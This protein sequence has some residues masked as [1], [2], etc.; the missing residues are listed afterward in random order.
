M[1]LSALIVACEVVAIE[2]ALNIVE[3]DLFLV[4]AFPSIIGG[5]ILMSICPKESVRFAVALGRRGWMLFLLMGAFITAGV[6]LWFD[7]VSRIGASKE[8]IL[9]GGST[10]VLFVVILSGVF[11]HER[12]TAMES[13]GGV[14][15]ILGVIFVLVDPSAM[16]LTLGVGEVEAI[17]SSL[18][19]SVSVIITT[20]LLKE[21]ALT[22]LSGWELFLGGI[23]VLLCGLA[24]GSVEWPHAKGMLILVLLGTFPALGLL[25][26]NAGLP[27]I[28]A[29][30]TSVLFALTG[31]MTVGVQL[32][33]LLFCP[34]ADIT[35][36][37]H[38][39]LALL[40]GTIAVVGV[41]MLNKMPGL[42]P[43]TNR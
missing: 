32:L 4:S 2:A 33:I 41:Y 9:G 18:S 21:H 5:L 26:Y 37:Q 19:L 40:G 11:L 28:G 38:V 35:L 25:T 30:L 31:I 14:L 34:D 3:L 12:L 24:F 10:E 13:F 8:A 42:R 23:M 36:P 39:P 17:A 6:L 1:L 43:L 16:R 7:S 20:V 29:S 22:P 15:I 27:K